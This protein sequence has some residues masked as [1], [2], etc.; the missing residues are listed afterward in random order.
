MRDALAPGETLELRWFFK[1]SPEKALGLSWFAETFK[2]ATF[3]ERTDYYFNRFDRGSFSLKLRQNN[4]ELKEKRN[5]PILPAIGWASKGKPERYAK[6]GFQLSG[7]DTFASSVFKGTLCDWIPVDKKRW[8]TTIVPDHT[9]NNTH[10]V[11]A[12]PCQVELT[13]LFVLGEQWW[14][15]GIELPYDPGKGQ[16][17][18]NDVLAFFADQGKSIYYLL[19]TRDSCGYPTWLANLV[20]SKSL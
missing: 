12:T 9:T 18:F 5:T 3:E 17:P 8:L 2:D 10:T 16:R 19:K 20:R 11:E 7:E 6:W 1:D 4:I 15:I 14:S 13:E